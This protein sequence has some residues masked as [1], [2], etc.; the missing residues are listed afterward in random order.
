MIDV[1]NCETCKAGLW[2]QSHDGVAALLPVCS[3]ILLVQVIPEPFYAVL[4]IYKGQSGQ[5]V[6]S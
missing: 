6:S 3:G 4:N 1:L 2:V 5:D